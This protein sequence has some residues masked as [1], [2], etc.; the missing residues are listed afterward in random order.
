MVSDKQG[1]GGVG[2]TGKM[3]HLS[4]ILHTCNRDFPNGW[5]PLQHM[6]VEGLLKSGS[7]EA[8]SLAEEIAIRWI[9]TNYIV[10]KKTGLMHEKFDVEHCGEF[11]GGGEYVPQVSLLF[12][13]IVFGLGNV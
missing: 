9:T 6:L 13:I 1:E 11:G 5:A 10:Y 4:M 7:Q 8:R 3:F 12:T 2:K